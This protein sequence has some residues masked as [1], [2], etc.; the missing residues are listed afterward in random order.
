MPPPRLESHA[1][2]DDQDASMCRK[3]I[4]VMLLQ[5]GL[6]AGCAAIDDR[7][8]FHRH[9]MSDLREDFRQPGVFLFEASTSSLYPEDSDA[10]E[11]ARMEWLAGW[12]KRSG[13]CPAGW[14][15]VSREPIDP[16]EVHSRRRDLR[17]Q[18]RCLA[19]E[20]AR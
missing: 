10:A 15:V 3:A 1:G 2:A 5:A 13:Y 14:E 12:M 16:R 7:T 4:W 11:A 8:D 17:Y 18:V 20:G 6:L 19:P 9:T